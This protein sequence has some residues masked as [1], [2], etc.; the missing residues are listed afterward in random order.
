MLV[1]KKNKK[2]SKKPKKILN[3]ENVPDFLNLLWKVHDR[4]FLFRG[5]PKAWSL[6]PSIAR[7]HHLVESHESWKNFQEALLN[8]FSKYAHQHF[9]SAPKDQL[10]WLIHAQHHGAPTCLLDFSISPLKALFFSV[11]QEEHDEEDGVFWSIS[12]KSHFEDHTKNRK[13]EFERLEFYLPRQINHRLVAQ[14]GCFA[15][16][17]LLSNKSK[18]S[19][20]D[21]RGAYDESIEEIYKWIV[22]AKCKKQLRIQLSLLGI[23]PRTMYPD[24]HGVAMDLK[25]QLILGGY[26]N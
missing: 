11:F 6:L 19:A 2:K 15:I 25:S 4:A 21:E 3:I 7:W 9:K 10:D 5:Q 16:F 17:P 14:Q 26:I 18:M 13:F 8:E 1:K 20:L 24:L 12:P 22:P 23:R